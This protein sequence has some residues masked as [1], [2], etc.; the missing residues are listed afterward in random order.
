MAAS[1]EE[2][3]LEKITTAGEEAIKKSEETYDSMISE[4]TGFYDKQAAAVEDYGKVQ[5]ENMDRETQLTVDKIKQN[6][7]KNEKD[8]QAEASAAYTDWQKQ[9]DEYGTE[10]ERM[11]QSGLASSGYSETSQVAMFNQYQQRVASAYDTYKDA[12]TSY[13]NAMAE[14]ELQ[15]SVAKAELAYNTLMS[16]LS[17]IL[18]GFQYKND[19]ILQKQSTSREIDSTYYGRYR[20]EVNQINTEKALAESTREYNLDHQL[21]LDRLN[22]DKRQ[23]NETFTENKR[24]YDESSKENKRQFNA[25]LAEDKRQFDEDL[26][27]KK[28]TKVSSSRSSDSSNNVVTLQKPEG[29]STSEPEAT[30]KVDKN[31][32][33]ALGYGSI[34]ASKLDELVNSGEVIEYEENGVL[35]YVKAPKNLTKTDFL[36]A[37]KIIK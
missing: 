36:I 22:E 3:R 31:S 5:Q 21:E 32:V 9:K 29:D 8:Y 7:E 23:Y 35:K 30:L 14:A 33:Q 34:S 28:K 17:L 2:K 24:Q 20:D 25:S 15:N 16:S 10:A 27:L 4:S 19:L 12:E 6:K 18:E 26:A 11:A 13:N 37:P 1:A